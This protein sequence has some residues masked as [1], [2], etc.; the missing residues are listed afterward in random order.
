MDDLS[1]LILIDTA[2]LMLTVWVENIY[3]TVWVA[4]WK[5]KDAD[6]G[7]IIPDS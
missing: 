4:R 1:I 5:G 3:I 7:K 6:K 2:L